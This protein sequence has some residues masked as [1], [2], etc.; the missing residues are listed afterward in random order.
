MHIE[1]SEIERMDAEDYSNFMAFGDNLKPELNEE[2]EAA[3]VRWARA[4]RMF[5]L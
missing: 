4:Q 1:Y 2:E 3:W 5:D